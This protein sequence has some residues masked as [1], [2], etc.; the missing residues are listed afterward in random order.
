MMR[1]SW[2]V[3]LAGMLLLA[4][5]APASPE[6]LLMAAT[7]PLATPSAEPRLFLSSLPAITPTETLLPPL[8]LPTPLPSPPPVNVW[9]GPPTYPGDSAAGMFFRLQFTPMTWALTEDQY[10]QMALAHRQ[11]EYCVVVPA[12][13][14]GLP[15]N[16]T[17]E[18]DRRTLG[19]IEYEVTTAY[20]SGQKQ[21]V[22]YTGGDINIYT[23]FQVNFEGQPDACLTDAEAVLATLKSIAEA[24]ATPVP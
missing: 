17:V 18:H 11:I 9:D 3:F 8:E 7:E 10:G 15:L 20:V 1:T 4:A 13:G 6:N 14:H 22:T 5:C 24:R 12:G 23:G 16:V 21:F 19:T 2:V